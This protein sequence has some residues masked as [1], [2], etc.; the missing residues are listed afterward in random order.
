MSLLQK[1]HEADSL[2]LLE[3]NS[4]SQYNGS[5]YGVHMVT[6]GQAGENRGA[7]VGDD[8]RFNENSQ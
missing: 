3:V 7:G 5:L 6:A 2:S 8:T 4:L 1:R